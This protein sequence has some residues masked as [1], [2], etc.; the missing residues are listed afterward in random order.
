MKRRK[1]N[2]DKYLLEYMK[3][4]MNYSE[5]LKRSIKIPDF[6]IWI[7]GPSKI[8]KN[9]TIKG[10]CKS[11]QLK[12]RENPEY[13]HY[14]Y[15]KSYVLSDF[16]KIPKYMSS[17]TEKL[18]FNPCIYIFKSHFSLTEAVTKEIINNNIPVDIIKAQCRNIKK[19]I[20]Y[21][22]SFSIEGNKKPTFIDMLHNSKY[23]VDGIVSS[24][25]HFLIT[26]GYDNYVS[27]LRA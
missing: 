24:Y 27:M 3:Y 18:F 6:T 9:L 25:I 14:R 15:F 13:K 21:E 19:N 20:F 1:S 10:I 4:N 11:L 22:I 26:E 5:L 12:R 8:G 2:D 7:R 17:N 16:V 23:I